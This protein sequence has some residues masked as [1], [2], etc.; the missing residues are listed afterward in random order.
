[1]TRKMVEVILQ[2]KDLSIM[3]TRSLG[4]TEGLKC[5]F[6]QTSRSQH[7]LVLDQPLDQSGRVIC[8]NDGLKMLFLANF[9]LS[10]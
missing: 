8:Q 3:A 1:M 6:W 9:V 4:K 7:P 5:S 2:Y 10:R